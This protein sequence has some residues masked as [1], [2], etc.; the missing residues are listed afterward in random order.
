MK[1]S[2]SARLKNENGSQQSGCIQDP[3]SRPHR[4]SSFSPQSMRRLKLKLKQHQ[5]IAT[6][7]QKQQQ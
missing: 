7:Q 3:F 2:P 1:K 5:I 4:A 6:K